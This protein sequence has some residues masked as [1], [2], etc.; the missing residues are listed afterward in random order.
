MILSLFKSKSNILI[1]LM[2]LLAILA[3]IS[4]FINIHEIVYESPAG[5]LILKD[6]FTNNVSNYPVTILIINVSL[7]ILQAFILNFYN[8]K[9][10]IIEGRTYLPGILLILFSSY[11][12]YKSPFSTIFLSNMFMVIALG[13]LLKTYSEESSISDN[14][15]FGFFTAIAGLFYL[16]SVIVIIAP[17]VGNIAFNQVNIRKWTAHFLGF[18]SVFLILIS[19]VYL[20]FDLTWLIERVNLSFSPPS[21]SYST[22]FLIIVILVMLIIFSFFHTLMVDYQ[23]KIKSRKFARFFVFTSVYMLILGL[24]MKNYILVVPLI[25]YYCFLMTMLFSHR[26]NSFF[27]EI[28]IILLVLIIIIMN[29][30]PDLFSLDLSFFQQP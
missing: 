3:S 17:W 27:K 6:S 2:P 1:I 9:H 18:A 22:E 11:V 23:K 28:V 29:I 7:I 14:F 16:P 21:I 10:I 15:L 20:F 8:T 19:V 5:L 12:L 26:K 13:Y 4:S 24:L 25:S 30:N